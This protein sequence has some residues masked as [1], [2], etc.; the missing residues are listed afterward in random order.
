M[1][2]KRFAASVKRENIL[3]CETAGLPLDVFVQLSLDALTPYD[4]ELMG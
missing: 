1:K 3:E 2:D 4:E